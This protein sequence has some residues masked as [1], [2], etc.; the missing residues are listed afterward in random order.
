MSGNI[1]RDVRESGHGTKRLPT[2]YLLDL[3][4][5]VPEDL[6]LQRRWSEQTLEITAVT[7]EAAQ[8]LASLN[9]M[10]CGLRIRCLSPEG[11]R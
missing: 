11:A 3:N 5:P 2:E 10:I 4:V 1:V 6:E 7:E 9:E 8:T